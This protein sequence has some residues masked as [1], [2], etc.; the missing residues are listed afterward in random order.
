[1][2]SNFRVLID[3]RFKISFFNIA[4]TPPMTINFSELNIPIYG[5]SS[6]DYII[7]CNSNSNRQPENGCN[8]NRQGLFCNSNCN[9]ICNI[10]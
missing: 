9:K 6:K 3:I 2:V 4:Q 1:M 8:S 7:Q 5:S 10:L